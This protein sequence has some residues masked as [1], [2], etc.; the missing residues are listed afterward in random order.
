MS[1]IRT[2]EVGDV[3]VVGLSDSKILDQSQI[4][5]IGYELISTVPKV[6]SGK[7]VL[8]LVG[9]DFM[10]SAMIGKIIQLNNKCKEADIKLH[11]CSISANILEVFKVMRLNK[12]L[13]IYKDEEA[14]MKG[15]DKKGWFG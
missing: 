4:E 8:T 12:V 13:T 15:F 6:P 10:G 14:A 2:R 1:A 11:V 7:M 9:V 3:F 5:Q